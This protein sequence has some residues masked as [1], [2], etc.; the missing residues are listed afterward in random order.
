MTLMSLSD[1]CRLLTIDPKTLRRWLDLAHV[2]FLAHPT[3]AR[4]KGITASHLCQIATAH[5]RILADFPEAAPLPVQAL[6][7]QEPPPLSGK[8]LDVL[9]TIPELSAQIV[10]LQERL[11]ELRQLL[12]PVPVSG[13]PSQEEPAAVGAEPA[14]VPA[15]PRSG[16]ATFSSAKRLRAPV[17]VLPLVEYGTHG[18]YMI[19]CPEHGLLTFQPDS[20]EW[21]AWLATRSSFRF[22]GQSGRS[23]A[24]REFTRV[25]GCAW[26]AHRQIRNHTYNIR[27]GST[28]SLTIAALEQAAAELQSHLA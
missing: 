17:H 16:S 27:L 24:H 11:T 18:C 28:E 21:F 9:Q 6:Q 12:H 26:R 7:L 5:H 3:D 10:V 20:T 23:T 14:P 25:P 13:S 1:C 19:I 22:V 4:I 8:L 15:T 2:P